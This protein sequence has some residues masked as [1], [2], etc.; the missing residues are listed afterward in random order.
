MHLRPH[1]DCMLL[2]DWPTCMAGACLTSLFR[3]LSVGPGTTLP[4]SLV[5]WCNRLQLDERTL[6]ARSPALR[7]FSKPLLR[8]KRPFK[9]LFEQLM[10]VLFAR[11]RCK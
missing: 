9:L 3:A 11:L 10:C 7:L 8:V 2:H 5:C 6:G 4:A 1:C